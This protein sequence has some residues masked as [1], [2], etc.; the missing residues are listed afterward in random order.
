MKK[1]IL[2]FIFITTV[3]FDSQK[4]DT[5]D[6]G[7]YFKFRVHYGIVT[8]GYATLEVNE[9]TLSNQK[10]FHIV[11]KGYNTGMSKFFFKVEDLIIYFFPCTSFPRAY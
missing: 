11:G 9:A 8:A 1:I 5:F 4:N 7:E 3:S 2:L 6:V 10:V